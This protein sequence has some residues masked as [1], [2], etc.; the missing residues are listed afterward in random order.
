MK[1]GPYYKGRS[2]LTERFLHAMRG[3][4]YAWQKEPNFRIEV[5]FAITVFIAMSVL[6]LSGIERAVLVLA[7]ALVLSLEVVN[8]VFERMLDLLHPPFSHEVKRIK[9][10]LAGVVLLASVASLMVAGF[11][12]T[13]PIL[14]FDVFFQRVLADFRTEGWIQIMHKVTILGEWRILLPVSLILLLLLFY[15]KRYELFGI[16]GGSVII[17]EVLLLIMKM[18]FARE[19]PPGAELIE[20]NGYSFPSG[21]VFLATV[22]W[23]AVGYII[24]NADREKMYLWIIPCAIIILV[25]LSRV[26]LSVHWFSDIA[27]GLLFG[28]FWFLLWFGINK[29]L[30]KKFYP[31]TASR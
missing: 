28:I 11:I 8:S 17:G 27:G 12:L 1:K 18:G 10:T 29:R 23:L 7:V 16:F 13:R 9:D 15:K 2:P 26:L 24:T 25:A 3:I 22:F 4:K 20:A 31:G 19:R 21:H 14:E 30:F 5:L 6:P